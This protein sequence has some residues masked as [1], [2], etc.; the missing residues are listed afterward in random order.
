MPTFE[1]DGKTAHYLD[2]GTGDAALLL[3]AGGSSGR[4]WRKMGTHLEGD[5]RLI[6]PDLYGFGDT[7]AWTGSG[8][9]THDVQA[10]LV[11]MLI[12]SICNFPVH[13]VGH[14]YGGATAMRL[15]LVAPELLRSIVF[16]EPI[17]PPLL[18]QVG[19]ETL[20]A[21]YRAFA[22]DFMRRAKEGHEDDAWRGF[23]NLRNGDGTW[24]QLSDEAR[25][26]LIDQTDGI[27]DAFR[28]NLSNPITLANCQHI[29]V[30][31]LIVCG[32]KTTAPERRVTEILRDEIPN[33]VYEII[34]DAEHMSPLTHPAEVAT[35]IR[36][37]WEMNS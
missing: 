13:L 29:T 34:P 8:D 27:V 18:P 1:H 21:E 5:Y 12:E 33:C 6:A 31:T 24:E 19:E 3:H 36:R 20:F 25:Q 30:P 17:L 37:H 10:E 26:R 15:W 22:E 14:S 16:I 32:A 2:V 4:Q 35:L 7:G 23:L 28:S 11:R 9:L